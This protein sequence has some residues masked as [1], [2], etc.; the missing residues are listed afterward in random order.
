MQASSAGQ[1]RRPAEGPSLALEMLVAKSRFRQM[2]ASSIVPR[3]PTQIGLAHRVEADEFICE[4]DRISPATAK[5]RYKGASHQV[6]PEAWQRRLHGFSQK[7]LFVQQR[8][9]EGSSGTMPVLP[10]M[11]NDL[12]AIA[13]SGGPSDGKIA[14]I[15]A[16]GNSFSKFSRQWVHGG[17]PA[18]ADVY[19]RLQKTTTSCAAASLN[20]LPGW[21]LVRWRWAITAAWC[22]T[23]TT[24][25]RMPAAP[26]TQ[27]SPVGLTRSNA[28]AGNPSLGRQ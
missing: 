26:S 20:F 8:L 9:K 18:A 16:D 22:G 17:N 5:R 24:K 7:H 1:Y 10:M 4:L 11:A 2:A 14:L 13:D 3:P 6:S 21:C 15:Y 19:R 23:R 27:G 12:K 28:Q 25:R